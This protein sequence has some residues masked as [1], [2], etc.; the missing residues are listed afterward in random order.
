MCVDQ[1]F[2]SASRRQLRGLAFFD[3]ITT[4]TGSLI[5]ILYF[6]TDS[7]NKS[8][9]SAVKLKFT[10]VTHTK[11]AIIATFLYNIGSRTGNGYF[12]LRINF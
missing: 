4:G 5:K 2:A 12:I 7:S 10:T 1:D 3:V 11:E 9:K 8:L 6:L